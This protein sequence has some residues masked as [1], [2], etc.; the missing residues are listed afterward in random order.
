MTKHPKLK[1]P[2][3]TDLVHNPTIGASK[4]VTLAQASP[5]DLD[6]L[7]GENAIEGDV[8]NDTNEEGDIDEAPRLDRFKRRRGDHG[9]RSRKLPLQGKKTHEQ[10]LRILERRPDVPELDRV[11]QA[12]ANLRNNPPTRLPRH[13]EARQSEFPVS[14]GGI[15]QESSHNKHNR[16]LSKR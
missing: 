9:G 6:E 12:I 10:Q 8:E 11:E 2:T 4:V 1:R 14:R 5:E 15:N 7:M 13:P 3:N 16:P